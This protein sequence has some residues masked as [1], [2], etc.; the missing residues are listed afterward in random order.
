[1]HQ[2]VGEGDY[3]DLQ[4]EAGVPQAQVPGRSLQASARQVGG[5]LLLFTIQPL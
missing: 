5:K 4:H 1:M 2:C 3:A